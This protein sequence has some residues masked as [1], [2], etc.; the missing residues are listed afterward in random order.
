MGNPIW[1]NDDDVATLMDDEGNIVSQY[2]EPEEDQNGEE[3]A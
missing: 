3:D 2:P 1:N